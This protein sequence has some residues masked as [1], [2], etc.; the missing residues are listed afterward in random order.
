MES[1]ECTID[2][3]SDFIYSN[4]PAEDLFMGYTLKVMMKQI[5]CLMDCR[6]LLNNI[7][8]DKEKL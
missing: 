3:A 5:H 6:R 2:S 4:S 1:I 8:K 7:I